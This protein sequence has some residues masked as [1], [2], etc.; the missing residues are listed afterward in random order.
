LAATDCLSRLVSQ[1][2]IRVKTICSGVT[3]TDLNDSH[4][5]D[6]QVIAHTLNQEEK[7][8]VM[9]GF[10]QS[11]RIAAPAESYEINITPHNANS[12]LASFMTAHACASVPDVRIMGIDVDRAPWPR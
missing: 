3:N 7:H 6:T 9:A 1:Y 11:R 10:I 2:N 8:S 4:F 5:Y 12:Y